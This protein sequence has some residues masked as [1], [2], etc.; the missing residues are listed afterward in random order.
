MAA[1]QYYIIYVLFSWKG[2]DLRQLTKNSDRHEFDVEVIPDWQ[3]G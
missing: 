3:Y 2:L 1:A